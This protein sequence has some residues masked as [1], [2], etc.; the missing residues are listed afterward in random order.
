MKNDTY[1]VIRRLE[2]IK[3]N[4]HRGINCTDIAAE[5]DT[6]IKTAQR[7]IR[8]LRQFFGLQIGYDEH[9]KCYTINKEDRNMP[10]KPSTTKPTLKRGEFKNVS[11]RISPKSQEFYAESF[12]SINAGAE[13]VLDAFPALYRRTIQLL[14]GRFSR[15]ELMLMIDVNNG[16]WLTPGHAGQH[17]DIQVAD[18]IALDA[19]DEKWEIDGRALNAKI[20]ALTIF[21]A[22]CLEL[23][24]NAFWAQDDHANIEEYVAALSAG[25]AA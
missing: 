4:L 15:G 17:M 6:T 1:H 12:D 8:F 16:L 7:D 2:W 23:W 5:W 21:E 25:G 10:R 19:L 14:K 22:A 18:G 9:Y 24:V 20:G 13:Y 11:P 3:N